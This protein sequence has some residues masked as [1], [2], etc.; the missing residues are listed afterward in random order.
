MLP[1]QH[2]RPYVIGN[3]T[4]AHDA[5]AIYEASRRPGLRAVPVKTVAQQD[6]QLVHLSR[7]RLLG[8]RTALVNQV[9]AVLAERGVVF[10]RG[11]GVLRC[12]VQ[13]RLGQPPTAEVSGL[14][15]TWLRERLQ[16]WDRLTEQVKQCEREL[17][18]QYAASA[19][20]TELGR[21]EGVGVMTATALVA[22]I[23]DGRQFH[24][25]RQFAAWVGLTPREDSSGSRR[26]LGGISKRG[27]AYL[28]KLLVHGARAVVRSAGRK[29]DPR[30]QWVNRLV[31]R[32]GH[33]RAGVALA[34]KNARIVW[35]LLSRGECYRPA[36]GA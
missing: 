19:A 12:G 8:A 27:D 34:N 2:V 23:G 5:A 7:E 24:S 22:S 28:R 20:C 4:D 15:Q 6:L 16:E 31:A 29:T 30:S 26:R 3:K 17:A 25:A 36:L 13:E 14:L 21:V 1:A 9:R 33:N 10:G 18:R 11:L 32:R 35:A